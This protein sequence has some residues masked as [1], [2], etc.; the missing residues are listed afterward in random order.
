MRK[1]IAEIMADLTPMQ[2][3]MLAGL[4]ILMLVTVS[5]FIL[6]LIVV[7]DATIGELLWVCSIGGTCGLVFSTIISLSR[8]A[9]K[10]RPDP[11]LTFLIV[12]GG[13]M[14]LALAGI[15]FI[16]VY[17]AIVMWWKPG[18]KLPDNFSEITSNVIFALGGAGGAMGLYLATKRQGTF[19]KQ[20]DAQLLQ[21]QTPL[22]QVGAQLLQAQAQT[23]QHFDDRLGRGVK[24]LT[25]ADVVMRCAGHQILQNLANDADDRQKQ[26]IAKIVYD[27]FCDRARLKRDDK[28]NLCFRTE[29]ETTQDL[30]DALDFII[31]LPLS[32]QQKLKAKHE[33]KLIFRSID[34]SHLNFMCKKL[35]GISFVD[36]CFFGTKFYIHKIENVDFTNAKSKQ[37]MEQQVAVEI[38][39][40]KIAQAKKTGVDTTE[41]ESELKVAK[42]DLQTARKRQNKTKTP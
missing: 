15:S 28:N 33:S 21:A 41:L 20:L 16:E 12:V 11:L 7:E 3:W 18:G 14:M 26:I 36:S 37:P 40:W 27:F 22:L 13:A 42:K 10:P 24:L 5:V 38:V 4:P 2:Y 31:N 8:S 23:E 1:I 29:G 35:K 6:A 32:A 17:K 9:D 25:N 30:Q 34:F 19:F 39:E